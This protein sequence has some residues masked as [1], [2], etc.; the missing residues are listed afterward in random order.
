MKLFRFSLGPDPYGDGNY[1]ADWGERKGRFPDLATAKKALVMGH[2][3]PAVL[4]GRYAGVFI[5]GV[6]LPHGDEEVIQVWSNMP[7]ALANIAAFKK[8]FPKAKPSHWPHDGDGTYMGL[9]H[10]IHVREISELQTPAV[11]GLIGDGTDTMASASPAGRYALSFTPQNRNRLQLR[12]LQSQLAGVVGDERM[13]SAS[14]KMQEQ[15]SHFRE[16]MGLMNA[17]CNPAAGL[18][19]LRRGDRAPREE[20][21]GLFQTRIYLDEELGL[22]ANL[23]NMDWRDVGRVDR[24]LLRSGRWKQLLPLPKCIL[25]TR[26]RRTERDYR[27]EGLGGLLAAYYNAYNMENLVW[28]RD[29]ENVWRFSTDVHFDERIFPAGDDMPG[30]LRAFQEQIW[31]AHWRAADGGDDLDGRFGRGKRVED[32]RDRA[33]MANEEEP[34]PVRWKTDA[35]YRT[36]QDWLDS[37]HYTKELDEYLRRVASERAKHHQRKRMPFALALQGIIDQRDILNIPRGADLFGED[38]PRYIKL[39]EDFSSGITD[40]LNTNQFERLARNDALKPGDKIIAY[41]WAFYKEKY[42]TAAKRNIGKR[43]EGPFVFT[44]HHWEPPE[45]DSKHDKAGMLYVHDYECN[46]RWA[47]SS[48]RHDTPASRPITTKL[49]VAPISETQ[50]V[51]TGLPADLAR[52]LLDDRQWKRRNKFAVPLLA[53]WSK[54]K[55]AIE[56]AQAGVAPVL[57]NLKDETDLPED[58]E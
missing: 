46:K 21:Y 43:G 6:S 5:P 47:E 42:G 54:V 12:L 15:L 36:L 16:G 55:P 13:A 41:R 45:P 32:K 35:T 48:Y 20:P 19:Q 7:E 1:I 24:W 9:L 39:I 37:E 49:G 38:A 31:T 58:E 33:D 50:W 34:C 22:I 44:V 30:L 8:A 56:A 28:V 17:Y 26:I 40:S 3:F 10:E 23:L 2:P 11:A 53:Q 52:R 4:T 51:P 14:E 57:V 29:G 27:S 25:V 18:E